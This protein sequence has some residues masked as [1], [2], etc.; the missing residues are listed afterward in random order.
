MTVETTQPSGEQPATTE[1]TEGTEVTEPA[2]T[3]PRTMEELAAELAETKARLAGKDRAYAAEAKALRD[4]L[5]TYEQVEAKKRSE[6]EEARRQNMTAEQR[7]QDQ[8]TALTRQLEEKDRNYTVELRKTRFPNVSAE[9]DENV[10]AVADEGKLASLEAKLTAGLGVEPPSM[11]DKN[12]VARTG[13]G[14]ISPR[15]KTSEELIADLQREGPA[16]ARELAEAS[17]R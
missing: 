15:E 14:P 13:S 5:S 9:L 1:P 3:Q 4:R 6:E 12:S 2:A 8:I 10:L 17:G 16:F 7:M 11:I